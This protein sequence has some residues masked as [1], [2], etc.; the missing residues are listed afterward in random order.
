MNEE[1]IEEIDWDG[2]VIKIHPKNFLKERMFLHK[3]SVI[4]PKGKDG[5]FVLCKRGKDKHPFPDTWCCAVGGKILA[6]ESYEDGAI[7]EMKEEIG[8]E[9]DLEKVSSVI[10]DEDDYK[11]IFN[12][13]TTKNNVDCEEFDLDPEEIQFAKEFS[14]DEIIK[15]VDNYPQDFAPTFLPII[16]EFVKIKKK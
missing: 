10:Y 11:A 15:M 13:F 12:I 1:L 8:K 6:N 7:R 3:V 9:F 5:K 4:I 16:K 2:K 14:I